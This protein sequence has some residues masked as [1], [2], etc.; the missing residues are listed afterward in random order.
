MSI[1]DNWL[2]GYVYIKYAT[3]SPKTGDSNKLYTN[4]QD[5]GHLF[6]FK[7]SMSRGLFSWH[8]LPTYMVVRLSVVY[9]CLPSGHKTSFRRL[10]SS[11]FGS[12]LDVLRYRLLACLDVFW[13]SLLDWFSTSQMYAYI[14]FLLVDISSKDISL[15]K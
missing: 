9:Q 4:C 1:Y 15:Y 5:A 10:L 7:H 2:G 12:L 13:L 6:K 8:I 3:E 14:Y 11:K